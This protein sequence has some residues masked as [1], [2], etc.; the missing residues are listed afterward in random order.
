MVNRTC[1]TCSLN[2]PYYKL[3]NE[4]HKATSRDGSAADIV[5]YSMD[6]RKLFNFIENRQLES[7]AK[8]IIE[9]LKILKMA[10]A[11]FGFISANTPHIVFD[12]VKANSPSA[13][14]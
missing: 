1:R 12:Q 3:I 8:W 4:K 6:I 10:G 14:N 11:D 9:G 7:L 5:I 2:P 13:H